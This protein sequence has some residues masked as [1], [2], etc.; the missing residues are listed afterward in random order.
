MIHWQN[1]VSS[2][3][4]SAIGIVIFAVAY[5]VAEMLLPFNLAKELS[6]DDNTA[7][8]VLMGSIMLGL[9]III[10]AAIHG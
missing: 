9:A 1:V 8:G 10:A 5:K 6:E 3:L 2:L 7:V 4:Y